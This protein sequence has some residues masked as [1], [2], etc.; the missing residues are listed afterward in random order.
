MSDKSE[1]SNYFQQILYRC[2]YCQY[3]SAYLDLKY[4]ITV[5]N[6][7]SSIISGPSL[8]LRRQVIF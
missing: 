6:G 7:V 1:T 4:E 2:G 5:G 8:F 3:K